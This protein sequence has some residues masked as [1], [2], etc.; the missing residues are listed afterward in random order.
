MENVTLHTAVPQQSVDSSIINSLDNRGELAIKKLFTCYF[1]E[2]PSQCQVTN[3]KGIQ[4][5]NELCDFYKEFIIRVI[6]DSD[7]DARQRNGFFPQKIVLFTTGEMIVASSNS[8]TYL[9]KREELL[10]E[11]YIK[12]EAH[13]LCIST[14]K[15][16]SVQLITAGEFGLELNSF[17]IG[18][19]KVDLDKNYNNNLASFDTEFISALND[20]SKR[21]LHFLYGKPGTG[22][23]NYLRHIISSIKKDVIFIPSGMAESLSDPGFINMLVTQA[24]GQVLI[25][26]DAE[27]AI[28]A[29]E[30]SQNKAVSTLLNISDGLLSDILNMQI[31]CTFNTDIKNVDAALLR[32]GRLLTKYEFNELDVVKA[33][34]LSINL[35]FNRVYNHPVSLS[36]IYSNRETQIIS[37]QTKKAVGF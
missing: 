15:L 22:K 37:L 35:G 2:L 10:S 21:G 6:H 24:R 4:L 29:R 12:D 9:Y 17:D 32:P 23:T 27:K 25:I 31:I 26:E 3:M 16:P 1:N 7:Y 14:A 18:A 28:V 34:T 19:T 33:N 36:E 13:R 20:T 30:S 8:F 5:A 11:K